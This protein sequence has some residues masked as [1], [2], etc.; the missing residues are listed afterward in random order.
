MDTDP[1]S[2]ELLSHFDR[3]PRVVSP[4]FEWDETDCGMAGF[5][6]RA[7]PPDEV[8][9]ED[10]MLLTASVPPPPA[11]TINAWCVVQWAGAVAVLAIATGVLIEFARGIA[12]EQSLE[13][14]ARAGAT[15]A[16]LPK[17][18]FQSVTAVV[19]QRLADYPD[20]V[21]RLQVTVLKDGTPVGQRLAAGCGD[22]ISVTLSVPASSLTFGWLQSFTRFRNEPPRTVQAE[23]VVPGRRLRA[24]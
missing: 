8:A 22:R 1:S 13:I 3:P 4:D 2:L 17:A 20:L 6:L 23:R 9:F 18:T 11:A 24:G 12:A 21:G 10:V 7:M 15:E 19:R 5:D 14:A 16:T